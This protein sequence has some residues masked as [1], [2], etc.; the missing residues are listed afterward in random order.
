MKLI[1]ETIEEVN[2]IVEES[3]GKKN[4]YIEGVFL[5]AELKNRNNRVYPMSVLEREVN[6]ILLSTLIIIVLLANWV[7]L[8]VPPSI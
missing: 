2:L 5:Q 3:G 7:T 8:M 6:S 1:T 4:H